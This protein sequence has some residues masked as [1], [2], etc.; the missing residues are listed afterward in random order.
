MV[1]CNSWSNIASI[2]SHSFKNCEKFTTISIHSSVTGI[3]DEA[4]YRC[5]FAFFFFF[6]FQKCC[7]SLT[8]IKI[9]SSVVSIGPESFASCSSVTEIVESAFKGCSSLIST[10]INSATF[11]EKFFIG[12]YFNSIFCYIIWRRCFSRMLI[13]KRN[14]PI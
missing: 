2:G 5:F 9:S 12:E 10:C 8:I 3:N 11:F 1:I 7:S 13:F 6:I 4:F 14:F